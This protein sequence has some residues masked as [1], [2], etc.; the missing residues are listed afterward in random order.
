MGIVSRLKKESFSL[1]DVY[2]AENELVRLFP[3]NKNIKA[4]VRQQLQILR[5]KGWLSFLGNGRY[6]INPLHDS[7]VS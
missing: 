7:F 5:D 3:K 6:A 1:A 2:N 4:K